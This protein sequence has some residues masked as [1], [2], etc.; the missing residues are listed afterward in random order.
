MTEIQWFAF[1]ILPATL[2]VAVVVGVRVFEHF[3]PVP[4]S[5]DADKHRADAA[6][7]PRPRQR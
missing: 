6:G 7:V 3:N 2:A 1:V 5:N 4:V